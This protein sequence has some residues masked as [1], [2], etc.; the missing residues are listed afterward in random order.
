MLIT[1]S[2]EYRF[3]N[4][5]RRNVLV[6]DDSVNWHIYCDQSQY[7]PIV[8]EVY[9]V[10]LFFFENLKRSLIEMININID[11]KPP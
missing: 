3:E 8:H 11:S 2:L 5:G 4:R 1:L 9:L 7:A 6:G 10:L